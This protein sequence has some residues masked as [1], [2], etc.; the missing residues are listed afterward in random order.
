MKPDPDSNSKEFDGRRI[1]DSDCE[2]GYFVVN[3]V[4]YRETRDEEDRRNYMREYMRKYRNGNDVADV[5]SG[6]HS[7]PKLANAE[8]EE[9]GKEEESKGPLE[10][11]QAHW[12]LL[13]EPFP[14]I[15]AMSSGRKT[16]LRARL[17]EPQWRKDWKDA[18]ETMKGCDFLKGVNKRGW[19]ANVDFFLR[20]ETVTRIM[21]GEFG[22]KPKQDIRPTGA[23][24]ADPNSI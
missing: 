15:R 10:E 20:P 11:F 13:P 9:E 23:Y 12:N 17:K 7:K 21:E 6:K 16:A 18:I 5:N 8:G 1:I 14:R 19:V 24:D 4:K 2:R 3:Y 22:S